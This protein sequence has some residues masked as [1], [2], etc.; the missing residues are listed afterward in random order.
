M[1]HLPQENYIENC[2]IHVEILNNRTGEITAGEYLE[3]ITEIMSDCQ[4]ID[5]VAILIINNNILGLL[6]GHPCFFLFDSQSKDQIGRM[7][8]IDTTILLKIDSLQSLENNINQD[9]T[10]IT[11]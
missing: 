6:W 7:S 10:Q 11:K 8:P 3:S 1:E 9:I 4:Q 5:T 2:P